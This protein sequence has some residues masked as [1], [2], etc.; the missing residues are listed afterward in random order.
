[1]LWAL[2]LSLL[3][4]GVF[5]DDPDLTLSLNDFALVAD[6]F[7]RR[8]YFHFLPPSLKPGPP[9]FN[10]SDSLQKITLGLENRP[11]YILTPKALKF[12]KKFIY[13][14]K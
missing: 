12:N 9:G 4:L 3:V 7:Y 5:T 13:L 1:M 11:T 14:S 6:R 10:L 8:S 2:A